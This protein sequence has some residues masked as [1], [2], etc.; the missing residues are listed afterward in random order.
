MEQF[1]NSKTPESPSMDIK[2]KHL[3]KK[4]ARIII[5]AMYLRKALMPPQ[6]QRIHSRPINMKY[7]PQSS[8]YSIGWGYASRVSSIRIGSDNMLTIII[9]KVCPIIPQAIHK[10]CK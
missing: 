6:Q 4:L 10:I 5:Q 7:R 9:R 2:V 8:A 1:V 3:A